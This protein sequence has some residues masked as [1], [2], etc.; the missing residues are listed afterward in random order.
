MEYCF[1]GIAGLTRFDVGFARGGIVL[2]RCDIGFGRLF[3][4]KTACLWSVFA[5][6]LKN[7]LFFA[8]LFFVCGVDS[9][10]FPR[11]DKKDPVKVR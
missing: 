5:V 7:A 11:D 1:W 10:L 6:C 8:C 2:T 4:H 9:L 3:F